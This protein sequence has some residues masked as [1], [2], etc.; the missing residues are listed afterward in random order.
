MG[1]AGWQAGLAP[2]SIAADPLRQH[3]LLA[4]PFELSGFIQRLFW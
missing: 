1:R 2:S 4:I 3:A